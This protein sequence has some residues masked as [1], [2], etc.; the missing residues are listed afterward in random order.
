M[1]R[2]GR[3]RVEAG[4]TNDPSAQPPPTLQRRN[5]GGTEL[6]RTLDAW[7]WGHTS[8]VPLIELRRSSDPFYDHSGGSHRPP[9]RIPSSPVRWSES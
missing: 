7:F 9:I 5:E 2:T 8:W 4:G 3:W 1:D 6:R